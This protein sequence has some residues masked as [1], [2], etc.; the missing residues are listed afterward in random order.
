MYPRPFGGGIP[1]DRCGTGRRVTPRS[2]CVRPAYV[3]Y[4]RRRIKNIGTRHF[5]SVRLPFA[6]YERCERRES[7]GDRSSQAVLVRAAPRDPRAPNVGTRNPYHVHA[8]FLRMA[9][10]RF[11][12]FSHARPTCAAFRRSIFENDDVGGAELQDAVKG[13]DVITRN[14]TRAPVEKTTTFEEHES[15]AT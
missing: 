3:E 13:G 11:E 9:F 6:G 15:E 2:G 7:L 14:T 5:T 8:R 12:E 10:E 4:E 1:P